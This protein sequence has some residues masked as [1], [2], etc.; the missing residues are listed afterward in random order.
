VLPMILAKKMTNPKA[1]LT[2]TYNHGIHG[3]HSITYLIKSGN[4]RLTGH[5]L[6]RAAKSKM[7]SVTFSNF[8]A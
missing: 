4:E 5:E 3:F 6:T 7:A 8:S 2:R 1:S